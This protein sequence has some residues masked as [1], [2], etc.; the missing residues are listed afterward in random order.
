[1]AVDTRHKRMSMMSMDSA[2]SNSVTLFEADGS[3]DGDDKQHALDCYSGIPFAGLG[4][5]GSAR[6]LLL[7][8]G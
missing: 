7:N 6:K 1:M 4:P 3:V 2:G 5:G 8:V